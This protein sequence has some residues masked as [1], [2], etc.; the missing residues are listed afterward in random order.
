M[1]HYGTGIWL[2]IEAG[3]TLPTLAGSHRKT[4]PSHGWGPQISQLAYSSLFH[5]LL[6][7]FPPSFPFTLFASI[8]LPPPSLP[9]RLGRGL[10]LSSFHSSSRVC[11]SHIPSISTSNRCLPDSLWAHVASSFSTP[12]LQH[13]TNKTSKRSFTALAPELLSRSPMIRIKI[14][15]M[16]CLSL[17][18]SFQIPTPDQAY[19]N[20]SGNQSEKMHL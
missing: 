16:L 9:R 6:A 15:L 14:F 11:S 20:S 12:V 17:P 10:P 3:R 19:I 8:H 1:P 5:R 13:P 4:R 18:Y 7:S 2:S